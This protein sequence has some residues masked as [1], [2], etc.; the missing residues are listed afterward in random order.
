[1]RELAYAKRCFARQRGNS[2]DAV[3]RI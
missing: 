3:P 2:W 1:V